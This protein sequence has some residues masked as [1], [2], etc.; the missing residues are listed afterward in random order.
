VEKV[1]K[2]QHTTPEEDREILQLMKTAVLR[3]TGPQRERLQA[4]YQKAV[5]AAGAV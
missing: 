3:L 5:E 1:Q 2:H 4:L